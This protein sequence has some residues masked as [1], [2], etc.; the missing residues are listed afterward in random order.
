MKKPKYPLVVAIV[1]PADYNGRVMRGTALRFCYARETAKSYFIEYTPT[2]EKKYPKIQ[3]ENDFGRMSE[4]ERG[5]EKLNV[6]FSKSHI[7]DPHCEYVQ[8]IKKALIENKLN[9]FSGQPI[10]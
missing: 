6:G 9:D 8:E 7:F 5:T 4:C 1:K 10:V 2:N 3:E